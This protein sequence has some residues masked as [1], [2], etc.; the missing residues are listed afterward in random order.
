VE[1]LERKGEGQLALPGEEVGTV[2]EFIPGFGTFDDN[3]VI[4]ASLSGTVK[5][6]R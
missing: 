3:G 5:V 6:S 1:R 2:E 4:R